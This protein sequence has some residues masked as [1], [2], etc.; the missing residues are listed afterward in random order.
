MS[1]TQMVLGTPTDKVTRH[2][3]TIKDSPGTLQNLSKTV[4]QVHASYQRHAV[5]SKVLQL[6]AK[7][8]WVAC[9]T[10]LV[11]KRGG[12]YWVIDGQHRVLAAKRRSDIKTLPCLVFKTESVAQEAQGF[13]DANT[14]R[15][16]VMTIDKYRAGLAANDPTYVVLQGIFNRL[17]IAVKVTISGAKDFKSIA[18]AAKRVKEDPEALEFVLSKAIEVSG[19]YPLSEK[20]VASLFYIHKN[21]SVDLNDVRLIKKLTKIGGQGIVDA[22]NRAGAYFSS[23]GVRIWADGVLNE[24]NKGLHSKIVIVRN[25]EPEEE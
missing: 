23:G 1:E 19:K 5:D 9:G 10:I 21:A 6:A 13:L 17:G 14:G 12:E 25:E 11:G 16:P 7:W 2:G 3:W 15:K 4:L 20:I 8:S 18:W 22:A 24:V